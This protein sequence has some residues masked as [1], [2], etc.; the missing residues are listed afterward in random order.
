MD[1]V[2]PVERHPQPGETILCGDYQLFPG[3]K[4]ANQAVAAARAGSVVS[5]VGCVGDDPYGPL[6][7]E[8][9]KNSHVG[10]STL[11]TVKGRTG[12]A[13]I[14]VDEYG[15]NTILVSRGAN[16]HVG[17]DHFP[18]EQLMPEDLVLLQM[19][20][21][22]KENWVVI[23][24]ASQRGA[25]TVLNLAP[26]APVPYEVLEA[27]DVL[28]V[29]EHEILEFDVMMSQT[30]HDH[31][32]RSLGLS[33]Q[34]N[35]T[36]VVTLGGKGVL[37][38]HEGD[39]LSLPAQPVQAVDTTAAGDAFVGYF[40]HCLSQGLD[41]ESALVH[42]IAAGGLACTRPGAQA[43]I[44]LWDEVESCLGGVCTRN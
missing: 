38:V 37:A 19:E 10:T 30:F 33:Q 41:L 12:C 35:M 31:R 15:E 16:E 23:Q 43:S 26:Q 4:G 7:F 24:Q 5:M 6:L 18:F 20:V 36:V 11:Q 28:I 1:M 8:N 3:G 13:V 42:G 40:A 29:N 2:L 25:R 22:L 14:A 21:P 44:P 27:L 39:V 32:E 17:A 9:L 34:F